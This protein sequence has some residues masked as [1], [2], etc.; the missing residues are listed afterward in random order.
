VVHSSRRGDIFF[1]VGHDSLLYG[2]LLTDIYNPVEDR[3]VEEDIGDEDLVVCKAISPCMLCSKG[4]S[5]QEGCE[6]TG[7]RSEYLCKVL[8]DD[9]E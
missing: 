1:E 8:G 4:E 7:R 2:R 5:S 6:D 3:F 9:G